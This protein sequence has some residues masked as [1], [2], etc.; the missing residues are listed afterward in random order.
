MFMAKICIVLALQH[1]APKVWSY[2]PSYLVSLTYNHQ[3]WKVHNYTIICNVLPSLVSTTYIKIKTI[4]N[5]MAVAFN[6]FFL[7]MS[8]F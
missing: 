4:E 7:E 8:H 1:C 5:Y 6:V 3:F 2:Y